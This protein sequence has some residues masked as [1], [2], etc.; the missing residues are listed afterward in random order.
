MS[1]ITLDVRDGRE[2]DLDVEGEG[3]ITLDIGEES[4]TTS[5]AIESTPSIGLS[6]EGRQDISLSIGKAS[7]T[8]NY[9][10]LIN[11]PSIED[12]TLVGNKTFKQLGLEAMTPQEI[13]QMIYG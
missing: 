7:G 2:I 8:S 6:V 5:L 9:E 12:V 3:G 11:K 10:A 13:D 1:G 4:R